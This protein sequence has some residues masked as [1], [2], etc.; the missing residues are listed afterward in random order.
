MGIL[1][2]VVS[3]EYEFLLSGGIQTLSENE[4]I[5]YKPRLGA[6][7]ET[8]LESHLRDKAVSTLVFMGCNFPNCPRASMYGASE[9]DFRIVLVSDAISGL[10]ERGK[11][12][13]MNIGVTA[14]STDELI[15][16]FDEGRV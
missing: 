13:M 16:E 9:R 11:K 2:A 7:Y 3:L 14:L 12:E 1:A 8:P 6:F 15:K 10:Y 5:I 4:V